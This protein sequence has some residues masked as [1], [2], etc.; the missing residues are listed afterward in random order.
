[1]KAIEIFISYSDKDI[2]KLRLLE[3]LINENNNYL[4][5]IIVADKRE[6]LSSLTDKVKSNI[7]SCEYFIPI[8]TRQSIYT[9]WVNQEIGFAVATQKKIL[10]IIEEQIMGDL[11]GFIHKGLDLSY[12]FE[13]TQSN[14]KTEML[15]YK[16]VAKVLINDILIKNDIAPKAPTI[17]SLFS[18]KWKLIFQGRVNGTEDVQIQNGN[19]YFAKPYNQPNFKHYFNLEHVKIDLK[20]NS[21]NFTK[22]GI[23]PDNRR[24]NTVLEIVETGKHYEGMEDGGT[25]TVSYFKIP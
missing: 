11:K 7:F 23:P 4:H 24:I 9:Q 3:K 18:G 2:K 20:K 5:P 12:K 8:L 13:G 1:M 15:K 21:I 22:V 16:K 14:S 10:P 19:Q 17:E 25:Q 6:V